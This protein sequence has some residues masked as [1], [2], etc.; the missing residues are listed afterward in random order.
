MSP[1]TNAWRSWNRCAR[2]EDCA[3]AIAGQ[4]MAR[5]QEGHR[6]LAHCLMDLVD[7]G[8]KSTG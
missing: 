4:D 6:S 8:L 1:L 3:L 5:I 7:S 2:S